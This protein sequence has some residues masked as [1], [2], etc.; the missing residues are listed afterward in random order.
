M[1]FKCIVVELDFNASPGG[2]WDYVSSGEVDLDLYTGV[3][4][5]AFKFTSNSGGSARE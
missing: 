2:S 1:H 4:N 5:L 3:I